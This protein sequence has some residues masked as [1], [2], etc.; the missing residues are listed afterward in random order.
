MGVSFVDKVDTV[1]GGDADNV[2]V[3]IAV[4][5]QL[6]AGLLFLQVGCCALLLQQHGA[7]S[8]EF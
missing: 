3:G 1:V 4:D 8:S 2:E 6:F 5:C 7:C